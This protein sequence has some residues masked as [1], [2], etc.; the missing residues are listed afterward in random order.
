MIIT[1]STANTTTASN[2]RNLFITIEKK[3][4]LITMT[5]TQYDKTYTRINIDKDKART[6]N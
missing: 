3:A 4:E 5:Y 2:T 1:A 6:C